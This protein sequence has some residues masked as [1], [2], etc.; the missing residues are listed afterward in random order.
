M[1]TRFFLLIFLTLL[2]FGCG[3]T[4]D[5]HTIVVYSPHGKYLEEDV[6]Q[7]FEA[8]HK[9]WTVQFLDMGGGVIFA[10]IKAEKNAPRASVWWGGTA[11]DFKRAET[12]GLF[13]N[14]VPTFVDALPPHA[15]SKTGGWVATFLTPEIIVYNPKKSPPAE[16]P[17]T[18]GTSL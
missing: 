14:Y 3:N 17:R 18:I 12:L 4:S 6:K 1:I 5:P 9:G 13:E 11:G 15:R 7:R 10:R 2:C 16:L 8:A